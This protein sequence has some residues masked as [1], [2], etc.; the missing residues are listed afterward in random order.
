VQHYWKHAT[1]CSSC[2][3]PDSG[4]TFSWAALAAF[5]PID[6]RDAVKD[7]EATTTDD[8]LKKA[9]EEIVKKIQSRFHRG[10]H[11]HSILQQSYSHWRKAALFDS[12]TSDINNLEELKKEALALFDSIDLNKDSIL[13]KDELL[14]AF[15]QLDE[16]TADLLIEEIDTDKDGHI[17][18]D[19]LW[20]MIESLAAAS[21]REQDLKISRSSKSSKEAERGSSSPGDS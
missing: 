5:E 9:E 15:P 12:L 16:K 18:F 8:L 4:D 11:H 3:N 7:G 10:D 20:T 13:S 21:A 2:K 17:S 14:K 1:S 19:E 6:L